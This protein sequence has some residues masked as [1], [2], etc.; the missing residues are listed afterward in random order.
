MPPDGVQ[1]VAVDSDF[2]TVLQN[3]MVA[4]QVPRKSK[5]WTLTLRQEGATL[6]VGT[7]QLASTPDGLKKRLAFI[8]AAVGERGGTLVYTNGAGEA[9]EVADL[10]SQLLPS[11]DP[12]IR[13]S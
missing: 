9:E 6:P 4:T 5:L 2:S 12:S 1:T 13:S 10:I 8:A 3:L 11:L 7:L